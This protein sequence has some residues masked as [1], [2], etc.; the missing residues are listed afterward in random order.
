MSW[1]K[2]TAGISRLKKITNNDIRQIVAIQR[3][4]PLFNEDRWCGLAMYRECQ[5]IDSQTK[6]FFWWLHSPM[7]GSVNNTRLS[8]SVLTLWTYMLFEGQISRLHMILLYD[9]SPSCPRSSTS[10]S[11]VRPGFFITGHRIL[12]H[13]HFPAP[14]QCAWKN[15]VCASRL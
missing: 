2:K 4:V 9:C 1:L 3:T 11:P 8:C 13:P 6:C 14:M 5:L 15:S 10:S 12:G 7:H